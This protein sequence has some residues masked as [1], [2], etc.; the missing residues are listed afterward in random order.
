MDSDTEIS[1]SGANVFLQLDTPT[2]NLYTLNLTADSLDASLTGSNTGLIVQASQDL[3]IQDLNSDGSSLNISDGYAWIDVAGAIS[4]DG[5]ISINDSNADGTENGWMYIGYQGNAGFGVNAPLQMII[6][7]SLES[8]TPSALNI[9]GSQLLVRQTG[10]ASNA[11]TLQFTDADV[12]IIGGNAVFDIANE[13][14]DPTG[15]GTIAL[16]ANSGITASNSGVESVF[17]QPDF[18]SLQLAGSVNIAS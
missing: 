18:T 5:T 4:L 17:T 10:A 11:N 12:R 3:H 8:G 7:G 1:L 2:A 6:D 15:Y 9:P 13:N 14:T 16:S